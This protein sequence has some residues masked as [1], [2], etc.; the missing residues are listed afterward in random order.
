MKVAVYSAIFGGYE[1]T[2]QPL[3]A[4]LPCPA[5]MFTDAPHLAATAESIGWSSVVCQPVV[6]FDVN[7]ANGDP[8]ITVPMLKHKWFKTHP[9][10]SMRMA[11]SIRRGTGENDVEASIWL[12][13][14]MRIK[15]GGVEFIERCLAALGPDDW[16]AMRH[17]WRNCIYV[18]AE[19][20]ATVC[21]WRYDA[22][23]IR[24]QAAA[25]EAAGYP[26][27]AGLQATG[28]M[29][30]RHTP[31]VEAIGEAW[32]QENLTWSHQDQISLPFVLGHARDNVAT[33]FLD[34]KGFGYNEDLPWGELWDLLPHGS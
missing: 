27:S 25:Y 32:W 31:L 13:G 26:R 19:Y 21:A 22:A 1:A 4:D 28:F 18:E 8:A 16:S 2:A 17:P 12:D 20:T 33:A 30:R 10:M 6:S 3:P 5:F 9:E 15:I 23:A 11:S 34:D 7:P 14:N 24:R 29:V